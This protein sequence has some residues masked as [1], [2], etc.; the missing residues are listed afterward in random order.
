MLRSALNLAVRDRKIPSDAG[1]KNVRPFRG[2]QSAR[3]RFLSIQEQ[4][5]LVNAAASPDFRCLLQAGLFTGA[6]EGELMRLKAYD[7]DADQGTIFIEESKSGKSRHI[8]LTAES[9]GFFTQMTAGLPSDAP[10]FPRTTYHQRTKHRPGTWSRSV[11]CQMMVDLC[12]AAK[13][14]PMVFHE[15]RHTYA[16]GLISAGMAQV[17]VAEQLGH[18]DTRMVE[19][20]YGH[21][22]KTAKTE[23]VRRLAPVLGIY[24]PTG[25]QPLALKQA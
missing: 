10:I 12:E 25:V 21:L 23:A 19:K 8:T 9:V 3:V 24:E 16:S 2:T 1:W 17:F 15:L 5:R 22:C 7:F 11:L 18:K 6:R 4:Q 14:E 13:I 20:H